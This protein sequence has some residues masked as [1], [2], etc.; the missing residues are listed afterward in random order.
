[1]ESLFSAFHRTLHT[2][3]SLLTVAFKRREEC[4]KIYAKNPGMV[5]NKFNFCRI[6]HGAWLS[7][8]TPENIIL[9][10]RKVKS[11]HSIEMLFCA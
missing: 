5:I 1:M 4:H 9:G 10:F 3:A 8:V 7:A 2:N 6:F 11:T